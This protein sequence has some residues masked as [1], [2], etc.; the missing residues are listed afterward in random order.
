MIGTLHKAGFAAAMLLLSLSGAARAQ[1]PPQNPPADQDK[2]ERAT[3]L[4]S[5]IKWTFNFDAGWGNFG[6]ANSL[7]NNPK[8]PGVDED[9]SDQWFEGYVKPALSAHYTLS[10]ESELYGKVSAV[11]ERTYG[12]VPAAFGQ[13]VS[14]F[15]PEDLYIGWRSGKSLTIGDNAVDLSVGRRE[16][17]LGH[18]FLLYDG[19]AEGGSR[20]GYWTNAR[21]AFE[22][23][24]IAR[25]SPAGPHTAEL[26]YLDKDELPGNDTGSTL[27]GF[28]YEYGI[29][30]EE[31]KVT[32]I[33]ATYMKWFA[34]RGM[35]PQ[36]DGLSVFNV[37][38]Y[39][40]TVP[41]ARDVSFEFEFASERNG[42]ALNSNAWTI[43]GGY[44]LKDVS[45]MPKLSY[46]Y[47]FFQG[48]DPS[49]PANESFDPLF[50][51]FHDWGTWWQGE[52]AGEY[53]LS[54]SNLKS[55]L[56]RAHVT[57][58]EAIGG[59][60]LFFKFSLD[61]PRAFGPGVTATDVAS[62]ID[63]YT[64]WKLNDNFT[65]SLIGAYADPGKAVQQYTG[66]TKNLVYGMVYLGY[67]F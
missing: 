63:L 12:S 29:G 59:G 21:K 27:W 10:S 19:A 52:I 42:D 36:R 34:D 32:T 4:P 13:D 65:V 57:P 40:T 48:D 17:R 50:P 6:F 37:R 64:D 44:E 23:A 26:F 7:Y 66:R 11:G 53:F 58:N 25:F 45:W 8:E 31:E 30:E 22:F 28:N 62:E 46:R 18:G 9:L 24:A 43:L 3:G 39:V 16:Y 20:G 67:S 33:G 55:H 60:L 35:K 1:D 47:A 5:A 15:G 61:H 49:T 38:A 56:I 14:S 41:V 54:N 51:G 2:Q